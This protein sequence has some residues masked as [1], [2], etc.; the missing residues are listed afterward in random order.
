MKCL[1]CTRLISDSLDRALSMR[2]RCGMFLHLL[3][4]R[5]CTHFR[6]NLRFIR[7]IM[8]AHHLPKLVERRSTV[9]HHRERRDQP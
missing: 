2:E 9:S 1:Q 3:V 8:Q 4:C 7:Q 5:D 6:R